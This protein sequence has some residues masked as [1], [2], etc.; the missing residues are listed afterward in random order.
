MREYERKKRGKIET[1]VGH[2]EMLLYWTELLINFLGAG[3]H[4]LSGT[5]N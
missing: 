1:T 5:R 4:M 2:T 3:S